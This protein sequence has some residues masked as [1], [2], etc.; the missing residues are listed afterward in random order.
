MWILKYIYIEFEKMAGLPYCH[1]FYLHW[2]NETLNCS[3]NFSLQCETFTYGDWAYS[4]LMDIYLYYVYTVYGIFFIDRALV[5]RICNIPM[6]L[7]CAFRCFYRVTLI[8]DKFSKTNLG[9]VFFFFS[10]HF[11]CFGLRCMLLI[12]ESL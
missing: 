6:S 2:K 5:G 10:T 9:S 8:Q 7:M 1:C 11:F 12:F 3:D 4:I